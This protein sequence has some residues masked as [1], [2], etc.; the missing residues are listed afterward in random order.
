MKPSSFCAPHQH[1]R[2]AITNKVQIRTDGKISA[3]RT[4]AT[5]TTKDNTIYTSRKLLV[6]RATK[7]KWSHSNMDL[8]VIKDD[9]GYREDVFNL[10]HMKRI[11]LADL[12]VFEVRGAGE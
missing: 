12:E 4:K 6:K 7:K 9:L 11:L 5:H 2:A 3:K 1:E 10:P 8:T